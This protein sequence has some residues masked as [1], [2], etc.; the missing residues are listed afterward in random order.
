MLGY[1]GIVLLAGLQAAPAKPLE[2]GGEP[3]D[4]GVVQLDAVP[5]PIL[6]DGA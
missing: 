6:G 5:L 3:I 4:V 1:S 2:P